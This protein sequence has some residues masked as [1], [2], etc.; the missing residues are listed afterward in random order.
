M[1]A[2]RS[3]SVVGRT[4]RA[5]LLVAVSVGLTMAGGGSNECA[6]TF[7]VLALRLT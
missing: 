1:F 3:R 7:E 5:R 2:L 4:K 6:G